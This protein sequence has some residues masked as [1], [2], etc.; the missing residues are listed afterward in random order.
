MK[1]QMTGSLF[2]KIVS[3]NSLFQLDCLRQGLM[4]RKIIK[5]TMTGS[6]LPKIVSHKSLF[7]LDCLRAGADDQENHHDWLSFP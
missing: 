3:Y 7:Q 1:F 6:L 4:I 5:I 2:P